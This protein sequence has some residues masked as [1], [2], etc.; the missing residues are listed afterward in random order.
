[1]T[2]QLIEAA[3]K[4]V[5]VLDE[6]I[7]WYQIRDNND[8]PMPILNQSPEIKE[9]IEVQ[10]ALRAALEQSASGIKQ[11]INLYDKPEQPA[12]DEPT[13]SQK[14]RDAGIT[15]RPKGWD[16]DGDDE[17]PAQDESVALKKGECWP[18]YVMQEWDYWRK[19]IADGDKGSAPRDWFEE[20]AEL[21]LVSYARCEML[22]ME[23]KALEE[24]LSEARE[25]PAQDEPVAKIVKT[26]RTDSGF[27]AVVETGNKMLDLDTPLYTRPQAREPLTDEQIADAVGWNVEAGGKALPR[28]IR[29]ARAIEQ[30][31]GIGEKK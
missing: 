7:K 10:A 5:E 9:A 27:R 23:I 30:A 28:E 6:I 4:A 13:R 21:K 1:M 26:S 12:Q 14:L 19:Q 25:Q 24:K 31:H 8:A 3:H 17:Q 15:R 22:E 2:A 20:L 18:E 29:I 11:V 16:K